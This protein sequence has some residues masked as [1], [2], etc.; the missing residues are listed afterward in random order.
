MIRDTY[1]QIKEGIEVRQNLSKLRQELKDTEQKRALLYQ[2]SGE[3]TLFE[4]LLCHEDPKIRKNAALIMGQLENTRFVKNLVEAYKKEGTLFVKSAYLTAIKE[5]DFREYLDFFRER[6]GNLSKEEVTEENKKHLNEEIRGLSNLV[7]M[8]EG[9]K[10]H[11]FNGYHKSSE[12]ILLTNRNFINKTIEALWEESQVT[13]FNAGV[14]LKTDNL[15]RVMEVRTFEELF[16]LVE[17]MKNCTMDPEEAARKIVEAGLVDFL[18]KRH[19]GEVPFYF[20]IECKTKMLLDKKSA[21]TKKM[22][23]ELERLSNRS[24]INTTS[25]Y[26]V[27]LRLVENKSGMFNVMVKLYT[28]KDERFSYR[29]EVLPTSIKP[30][31]AALVFSL[32]EDYLKEEAKILDPFC[33]TGTMLIER[34]KFRKANTMYGIDLFGE[35]IDKAKINT[36]AAHQII[37]YIHRDFFDF[38][39]EYL[40]DEIVTNMPT[41]TGRKSEEEIHSVYR[42]FFDKAKEHLENNGMIIMYSHNDKIVRNLIM[43]SEYHLE[44]EW[45]IS[46][47]EGTY[48]FAIRWNKM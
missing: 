5:Y 17:G 14:M 18:K 4:E 15:E 2:I 1:N 21:F 23:A 46:K 33:G 28:L 35:A 27:E 34:H 44:E 32:A 47:K 42:R 37:H 38:E 11:V 13:A 39:H 12:L 25:N 8:M 48:V 9:T 43:R 31:N 40:F 36:E 24:L 16:F 3:D 22:A 6:L 30:V 41:V 29:K 20:R 10:H 45:E 7:I 26:E 19:E